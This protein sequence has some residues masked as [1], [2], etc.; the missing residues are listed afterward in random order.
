MCNN[1]FCMKHAKFFWLP[2]IMRQHHSPNIKPKLTLY[3]NSHNFFLELTFFFFFFGGG[4]KLPL[5]PPV[6]ET[7]AFPFS[8]LACG[9]LLFPSYYN[10][11]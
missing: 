3:Y 6:V 2:I 5:H 10:I 1:C 11:M 9:R 8:L 7:L 4:E